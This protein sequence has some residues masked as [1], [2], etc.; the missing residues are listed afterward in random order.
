MAHEI[1]GLTLLQAPELGCQPLSER[2]KISK[3]VDSYASIHNPEHD[4]HREREHVL[5]PLRST[6]VS[7][8]DDES[9]GRPKDVH[10]G[11]VDLA[12]LPTHVSEN[13]ETR[14]PA[15][16]EASDSV[17]EGNVDLPEP[18]TLFV[19]SSVASARSLTQLQDRE[20]SLIRRG[21][22]RFPAGLGVL[23]DAGTKNWPTAFSDP[24]V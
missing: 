17:R 14:K 16:E 7:E 23:L 5:N 20:G 4:P 11:S 8:R 21:A 19:T 6:A 10:W 22:S 2:P 12:R 3:E 24:S 1:L 15:C 13:A 9:V 18:L